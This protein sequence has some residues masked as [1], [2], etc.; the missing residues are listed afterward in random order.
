MAFSIQSDESIAL[1]GSLI[2]VASGQYD[3]SL[4][5]TLTVPSL[6]TTRIDSGAHC[7]ETQLELQQGVLLPFLKQQSTRHNAM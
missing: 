1:G 6:G 5:S 2:K 4:V 7:A 3:I